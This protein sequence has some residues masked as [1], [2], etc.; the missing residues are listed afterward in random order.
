LGQRLTPWSRIFIAVRGKLF[1]T[2]GDRMEKK[3]D[4]AS[5]MEGI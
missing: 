5:D 2:C 4:G 1:G 3:A